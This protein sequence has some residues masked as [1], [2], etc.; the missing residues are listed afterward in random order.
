MLNRK[1]Y[2][3]NIQACNVNRSFFHARLQHHQQQQ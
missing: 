3:I 1:L 2:T